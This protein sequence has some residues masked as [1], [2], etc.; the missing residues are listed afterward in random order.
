ME[1]TDLKSL[2]VS[3]LQEARSCEAQIADAFEALGA[4]ASDPALKELLHAEVPEAAAH[5]DRVGELVAAHGEEPV[6]H[7]DQTMR[8][9][10][11]EADRW[12]RMI[13]DEGARDAALIASA[14]RVQHYEIALYGSLAAW[15]KQLGMSDLE[16]LLAILEEERAADERL[17]EIA[18]SSVNTQAVA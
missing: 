13:G 6:A 18:K 2:Y 12:A 1:I 7:D 14:Q 8:T 4:K 9:L 5:R 10:L 15:A 16:T 11:A 17:T 3:E